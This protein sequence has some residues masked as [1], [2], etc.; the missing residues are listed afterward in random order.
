VFYVQLSPA[1]AFLS[2]KGFGDANDQHGYAIAV[3]PSGAPVLGGSYS[4]S[5]DF[6]GGMLPAATANNNAFLARL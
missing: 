1:G 6:G 3:T 2:S 5:I 4:G